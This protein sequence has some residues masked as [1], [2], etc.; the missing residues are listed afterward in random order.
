M[1]LILNFAFIHFRVNM[2]LDAR[3]KKNGMY[4][5]IFVFIFGL[6]LESVFWG[7]GVASTLQYLLQSLCKIF[8]FIIN[9]YK[10]NGL[11]LLMEYNKAFLLDA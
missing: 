5:R 3:S 1:I 8:F 4:L 10:F 6:W 7:E 2:I 9:S 11:G